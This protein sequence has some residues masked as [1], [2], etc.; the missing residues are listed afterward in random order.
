MAPVGLEIPPNSVGGFLGLFN[1]TNSDSSQNQI[2]H[3]EFDSFVNQEWDP[4]VQ[5]VGINNNSI[6][7]AVYTTWNASLHGGDTANVSII[8]NA[9]TNNLSVS[10]TYQR[11]SNTKE[12][13]SLSYQIE[14]TK[15]LPEWVIIGFLAATSQYIERHTLL[16][17]E[18][19]SCL[20]IHGGTEA[21]HHTHSG[22]DRFRW[23]S[24]SR[25]GYSICNIVDMEGKEKGENCNKKLNIN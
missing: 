6:S 16:S 11:T 13:T 22:S 8:Y 20:A 1:T 10:W 25:D 24:D 4:T 9:V 23:C 21:K 19:N 17:W 2:V 7:S 12:D 15:V 14:L 3:V 5:H 18:F